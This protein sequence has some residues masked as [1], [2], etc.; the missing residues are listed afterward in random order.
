MNKILETLSTREIAWIIWIFVVFVVLVFD[1]KLRKSFASV[2]K[3][4]LAWKII[5]SIF[6][7]ILN[8]VSFVFIL[9]KLGLWDEILL[10]DT[11]FWLFG[12]GFISLFNI[13][14]IENNTYFRNVL[15]GAIK[16]TLVFEFIVNFFT[17]SLLKELIFVPILV[18]IV[19][20]QTSASFKPEH[21]PV[22]KLF[23]F[24]L[25]SIGIFIFVFSLYKTIQQYDK[26]LTIE[27]LKDFILPVY[28]T[29]TFI[30]FLYIYNLI[31]KYEVLWTRLNITIKDDKQR[32]II[33]K[34]I[35]KVA[36]INTNK[37][38]NISK[39][40]AKPIYVYNDFS[41]EMVKT[42]SKQPYIG[43]DE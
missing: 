3:A 14:E 21:K 7:L 19:L 12:F 37:L 41:Y 35:I 8:T 6:A 2:I 25:N 38:I 28:L 26:L 22:E 23:T 40:I 18:F 24:L 11:I 20:M 4:L 30:P 43:S 13:N 27:N 29:I 9:N 32:A 42:I 1:K 10:K 5:V 15:W 31:A 17:F 33:K 34:Y 39:N 16:W 36:N